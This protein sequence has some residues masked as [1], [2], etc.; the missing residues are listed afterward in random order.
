MTHLVAGLVALALAGGPTED[1]GPGPFHLELR[2]GI[3]TGEFHGSASG[4]NRSAGANWGVRMG[5]RPLERLVLGL[6]YGQSS[7]GCQ[8][9]LCA[10]FPV[11]FSGRG[12]ELAASAD[13]RAVRV[14]TGVTRQTLGAEWTD[15]EGVRGTSEST[16]SF[17]WFA[18]LTLDI[19]VTSEFSVAPGVRYM[20][21][22]ADF[23]TGNARATVQVMA[24][25]GLRYRLP[26]G[27]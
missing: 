16:P 27:R 2:G 15:N 14:G 7:F 25:V 19:P 5:F 18:D 21:H 1:P 4:E 11:T 3:G 22:G 6:G 12:F 8:G 17:G 24:D 10:Q 23:G 13:W 26:F 9:G 20:R